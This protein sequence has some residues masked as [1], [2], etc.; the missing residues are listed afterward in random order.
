MTSRAPAPEDQELE[1]PVLSQH[2]VI[3]PG[4][5]VLEHLSR[6]DALDVYAVWSSGR[7]CV[8]VAKVIRPDR[9]H[10]ER[11]RR[12]LLQE[13]HLLLSLTH[14]HLVRA[15]EVLEDP[16]PLV[17]LE[18]LVGRRLDDLLEDQA[19]P[20]RVTD[21]GYLGL[22]LASALQ[23]LHQAGYLHLDVTPTNVMA[24]GGLAKLIDLSLARP[25]GRASRGIGT[26]QYLSPEQATGA[27]LSAA[28]DVWGLA[29]TLY[30]AATGIS[31]FAE[32]DSGTYPQLSARAAPVRSLRA[33]L[34]RS[35]AE[36]VDAGL[37]PDPSV[38]P[39]VR[40]AMDVFARL[41]P[42]PP[43]ALLAEAE[44]LRPQRDVIR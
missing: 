25:P 7:G 41:T 40:E 21:L 35:F 8:C 12:R 34:P 14:P 37:D 22:H 17:V 1:P 38:R 31:P 26:H 44:G 20:S 43:S 15:Y 6:G 19:R 36:V 2:D 32:D 3:A 27:E 42:D 28:S 9:C 30:E 39:S 4:L 23:Y 16:H 24:C 11:V 33:R 13:G 5:M 29:V 10:E 18:T